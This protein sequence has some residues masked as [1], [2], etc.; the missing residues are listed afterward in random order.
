MRRAL[1]LALP[2]LLAQPAAPEAI[3]ATDPNMAWVDATAQPSDIFM[4]D[5]LDGKRTPDGRYFRVRQGART[6]SA[7]RIRSDRGDFGLFS[8][9]HTI[10]CTW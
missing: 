5:Q 8:E 6:R 10:R 4:S 2:A 3:A 1:P 7:L 9:T